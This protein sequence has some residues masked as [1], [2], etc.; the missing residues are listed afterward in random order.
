MLMLI[1]PGGVLPYEVIGVGVDLALSLE[2]LG[3][4]WYHNGQKLVQNPG[5]EEFTEITTQILGS[6]LKFK[7]QNLEYLSLIV[8]EAKFWTPDT[9]FRGTF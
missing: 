6:Y 5:K 8:L 2:K 7:A 1:P 9:N 4:F 3:K